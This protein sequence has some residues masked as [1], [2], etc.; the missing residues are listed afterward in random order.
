MRKNYKTLHQ[1]VFSKD[2][3][4]QQH[5]PTPISYKIKAKHITVFPADTGEKTK[6]KQKPKNWFLQ[7]V[8]ADTE[9]DRDFFFL[10]Y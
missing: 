1:F 3:N 5:P 2:K 9:D 10:S 6:T 4:P 7:K 8:P